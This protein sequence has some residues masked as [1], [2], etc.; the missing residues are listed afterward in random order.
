MTAFTICTAKGIQMT[1]M[2]EFPSNWQAQ[3][4]PK[5]WE[6]LECR[7]S[8]RLAHIRKNTCQYSTSQLLECKA[9][10]LGLWHAAGLHPTHHLS[11]FRLLLWARLPPTR[12]T[13]YLKDLVT[14]AKYPWLVKSRTFEHLELVKVVTAALKISIVVRHAICKRLGKVCAG[15]IG[16]LCYLLSRSLLMHTHEITLPCSQL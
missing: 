4:P 15:L 7:I 13:V 5:P 10:L 14:K 9:L 3:N 11:A 8:A 1:Q 2:L 16:R 6:T 12:Q